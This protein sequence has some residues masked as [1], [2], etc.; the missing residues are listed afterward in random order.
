LWLAG[1]GPLRREL[2]NLAV[3]LGVLDRVRFLGWRTDRAALLRAADICVLPSRYEPFGTVILEAW[4][5]GTPLV[6]CASAGPAAHIE[7]GVSGLLTP[8]NDA[9]ALAVALRRALKDEDLRRRLVAQGYA[10]YIRDYTRESVTRR[11]IKFYQGLVA[12]TA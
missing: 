1:E 4:A 7:D 11:W 9:P 5:A 8:I 2:E 3:T 6:A 12:G 10:V